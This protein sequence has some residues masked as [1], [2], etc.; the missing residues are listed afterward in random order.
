MEVRLKI[1][2]TLSR[3]SS[4]SMFPHQSRTAEAHYIDM[5]QQI[6]MPLR[7][8]ARLDNAPPEDQLSI[9]IPRNLWEQG[10]RTL[11]LDLED[12]VICDD[13]GDVIMGEAESQRPT[14]LNAIA[15]HSRSGTL[16]TPLGKV[17]K[18]SIQ[19]SK[20]LYGEDT[21]NLVLRTELRQLVD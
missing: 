16:P 17:F 13:D 4:V 6:D 10:K 11:E 1:V 18:V 2:F 7:Q 21:T 9:K 12:G 3:I 19:Q 15:L 8:S 20:R 5:P 14:G